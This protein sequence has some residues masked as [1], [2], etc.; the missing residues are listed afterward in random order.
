MTSLRRPSLFFAVLAAGSLAAACSG[1][2]SPAKPIDAAL[3]PYYCGRGM[4]VP[5]VIPPDGFCLKHFAQVTEARTLALAPNGDLFVGAPS[6]GTPGGASGG[7]GAIVV[8]SDDD[9]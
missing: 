2:G 3:D 9:H 1:S 8:L 7:P 4:T 5:G 6:M